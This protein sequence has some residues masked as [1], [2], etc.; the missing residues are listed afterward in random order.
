MKR[1]FQAFPDVVLVDTT[2]GTNANQYELL[3]FLVTDFF[4]KD[5]YVQHTLVKA[6]T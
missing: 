1:L 5:Q 2:H 6:E 3:N 4:G